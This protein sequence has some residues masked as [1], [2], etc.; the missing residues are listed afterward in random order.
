MKRYKKIPLLFLALLLIGS[1]INLKEPSKKIE[2]YTFEYDPSQIAG[3]KPLPFVIRL[4]RFS[5]APTYNSDQI[6]YRDRSFRREAYVYYKWRANPG[7][8]VT[9]F[10]SR[11]MK[12]SGLFKAVLPYDSIF[13]S[14]FA[15]EGSVDQFFEW[16]TE[17][18]WKAVLT[19]SIT[20]MKE[21]EP[22][23]SKRVLFQKTYGK[24]EVCKKKNPRALAEAMSRAMA[25]VSKKIIEDIYN[26]LKD[27]T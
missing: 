6:I 23:I 19:I 16:D 7:D 9:Y 8:L 11:D 20:L 4:V 24:R 12:Q 3:L 26:C 15:V 17:K 21:N 25:G 1:C 10:L 18:S 14:S 27:R 2:Y 13:P 5:V 22:D